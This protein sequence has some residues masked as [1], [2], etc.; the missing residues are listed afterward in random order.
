MNYEMR[1]SLTESEAEVTK[2]KCMARTFCGRWKWEIEKRIEAKSGLGD[3]QQFSDKNPC[4][5]EIDVNSLTN[6]IVNHIQQAQDHY[7]GRGS[8]GIVQLQLFRGVHVAVK[9]FHLRASLEDLQQEAKIMVSLCHPCLPYL[10]GTCT[11][12]KPYKIVM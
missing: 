10:F 6:P 5:E 9:K 7:L 11:L 8:F 2:F 1:K 3:L 12:Q 4:I